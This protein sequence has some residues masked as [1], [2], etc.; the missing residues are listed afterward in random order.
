MEK[1]LKNQNY[2]FFDG[3]LMGIIGVIGIVWLLEENQKS[4]K[5]IEQLEKTLD[6][7]FYLDKLNLDRDWRNV[8]G[9]IA[10]SYEKLLE[11]TILKD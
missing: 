2:S 11:E 7:G 6:D 5:R 4:K 10:N 8:R 9:D 3:F 1:M